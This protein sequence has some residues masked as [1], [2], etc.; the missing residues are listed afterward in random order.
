MILYYVLLKENEL[1]KFE[2]F[3]KHIN[4]YDVEIPDEEIEKLSKA[5]KMARDL[6]K[7]M[8]NNPLIYPKNNN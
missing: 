7:K 1:D 8:K 3:N 6:I 5:I 2:I 4:D